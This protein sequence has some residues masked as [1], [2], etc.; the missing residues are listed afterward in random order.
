MPCYIGGNSSNQK[1]NSNLEGIFCL[2]VIR[3]K[4]IPY[5]L[6]CV[7]MIYIYVFSQ[8]ILVYELRELHYDT[9]L[10]VE[11]LQYSMMFCSLETD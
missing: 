3:R 2:Q 6:V 10:C 4:Q 7:C 11:Y 8:S 5:T 1:E 9:Q